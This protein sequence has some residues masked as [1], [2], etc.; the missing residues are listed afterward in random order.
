MMQFQKSYLYDALNG[1]D[2]QTL[3]PIQEKVIPNAQ[4]GR[5]VIAASETGTGKS[6][7]FLLPIF[8][9]LEEDV[10]QVQSVILVP[11]RDLATQILDMARTIASYCDKTLDIRAF[12][13][14]KDREREIQRLKKS[15]P[16]IVIGT[17]GKVHDLTVKENVLKIH[18]AKM[19]VIDEADMALE[20]GFLSE[21]EA[22]ASIL[23]DAQF[24]VFSAT[25][26]KVLRDFLKKS[27]DQP[28]EVDL[29]T[30]GLT[31]LPITH[32]FLKVEE[33]DAFLTL[34]R[35]LDVLNPYLAIVFAN[36]KGEVDLIASHMHQKNLEVTKLHGDLSQRQRKQVLRDIDKLRVQ[37]IVAS[38]IAARGIDIDGISHVINMAF[39]RDM[40][41][42][43]HRAGRTGRMGRSGE[44][45]TLYKRSDSDAFNFLMKENIPLEFVEIK[46]KTLKPAK[47]DTSVMKPSPA[48]KK[49]PRESKG[50]HA[51]PTSRQ[52]RKRRS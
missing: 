47:S 9:A 39:P 2:F 7:A 1:L 34:D 4:K 12:T 36:T 32:K 14:G 41:F 52:K 44:V 48:G 37:Y 20:I 21:M 11:T 38:D 35:L 13:G 23:K 29:G 43:I 42:Y 6:H 50:H 25:I 51:Q 19:L 33:K 10:D 5:D 26:P 18:T 28:Y 8:D 46:D 49:R 45:I 16:Q 17:P 24:M 22:L 27:M 15:Q 40:S 30:K 3:S 31:R